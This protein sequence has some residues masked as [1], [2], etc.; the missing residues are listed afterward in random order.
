MLV[1]LAEVSFPRAARSASSLRFYSLLF[2]KLSINS[3]FNL[4]RQVSAGSLSVGTTAVGIRL[5]SAQFSIL[6][7]HEVVARGHQG[8][9]VRLLLC[10][11]SPGV[12]DAQRR[13]S[14]GRA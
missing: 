10:E 7:H 9:L 1:W 3:S 12:P 13:K 2:P 5:G 11:V 6:V 4:L 8:G 14:F